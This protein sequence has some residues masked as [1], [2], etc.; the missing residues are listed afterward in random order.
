MTKDKISN[1]LT[2]V[3]IFSG[4]AEVAGTIVM[5]FLSAEL[6][7]IFIWY[8]MGFPI[9][10][11]I[12][13]F[14]TWNFNPTVLY[15]PGDYQNEDNFYA[16]LTKKYKNHMENSIDELEILVDK[17]RKD[18]INETVKVIENKNNISPQF[19]ENIIVTKMNEIRNKLDETKQ[20]TS[21][22][23]RHTFDQDYSPIEARMLD[24]LSDGKGYSVSKL[25]MVA[26][27]TIATAARVMIGL[28][29]RNLVIYEGKNLEKVY[30]IC[31]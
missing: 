15:S 4:I 1:P 13:F 25:A 12:L 19:L 17:T 26:G 29:H 24:I 8:V 7:S 18:I 27:V 20:N 14:I 6:Q 2:I 5:A 9:L 23:A 3:G 10:L 31:S 28:Y 30:K 22:F 11:V 21:D 16:L